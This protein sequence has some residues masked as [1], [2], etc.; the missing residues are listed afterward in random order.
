MLHIVNPNNIGSKPSVLTTVAALACLKFQIAKVERPADPAVED[1]EIQLGGAHDG[2]SVNVG[3]YGY[4]ITREYE[5]PRSTL[6][7]FVN[8]EGNLIGEI[9]Q[10]MEDKE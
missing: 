9:A 2:I 7:S 5:G 10:A 3:P 1:S 8:G 6:V 4:S